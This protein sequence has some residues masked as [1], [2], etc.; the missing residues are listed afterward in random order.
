MNGVNGAN[1]VSGVNGVNGVNTVRAVNGSAQGDRQERYAR[2]DDRPSRLEQSK[3]T[4]GCE[5]VL[6]VQRGGVQGSLTFGPT[7]RVQPDAEL[8]QKLRDSFGKSS[9]V[10]Q[11]Q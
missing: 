1:G 2:Y 5:I 3:A 8:I 11:Y 9:V 10:L 6:H 4:N 7:W